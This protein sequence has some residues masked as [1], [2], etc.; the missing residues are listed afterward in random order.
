[1]SHSTQASQ[2][3]RSS[4]SGWSRTDIIAIVA[5]LAAVVSAFIAVVTFCFCFSSTRRRN[6]RDWFR[7]IFFPPRT[8]IARVRRASQF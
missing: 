1:M 7:D 5:C 4:T 3:A 2:S 8:F 6:I